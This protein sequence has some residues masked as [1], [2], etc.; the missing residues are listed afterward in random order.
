MSKEPRSI[1]VRTK[2][3]RHG[4]RLFF[5]ILTAVSQASGV[6]SGLIGER[7][8]R[9]EVVD[10]RAALIQLMF[11][12]KLVRTA[13]DLS[14]YFSFDKATLYHYQ[15]RNENLMESDPRFKDLV[16]RARQRLA[17]NAATSRMKNPNQDE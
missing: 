14:M 13:L 15:H 2:A 5:D 4:D 11:E 17:Y 6:D 16:R 3:R 1:L 8:R 12:S 10:A 9:A 7:G